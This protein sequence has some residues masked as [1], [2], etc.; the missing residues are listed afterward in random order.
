M[1][2]AP[3][4]LHL[5]PALNVGGNDY[6]IG[7]IDLAYAAA[8]AHGNF[9]FFYSFDL[10]YPWDAPTIAT[11]VEKYATSSATYK[12]NNKV[13]DYMPRSPAHRVF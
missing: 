3:T 4:F 13:C 11:I 7:K 6:E 10:S 1:I 2:F 12:W 5:D 8:I 9:Q